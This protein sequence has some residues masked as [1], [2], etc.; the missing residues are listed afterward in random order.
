M[1]KEPNKFDVL[2][3][4]S[5]VMSKQFKINKRTSKSLTAALLAKKL[6]YLKIYSIMAQDIK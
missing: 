1:D 6:I 4:T 2:K 5:Q 3:F